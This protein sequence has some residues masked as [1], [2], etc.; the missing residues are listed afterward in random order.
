MFP[1]FFA[2]IAGYHHALGLTHD[3]MRGIGKTNGAA[4]V[5]HSVTTSGVGRFSDGSAFLHGIPGGIAVPILWKYMQKYAII[6]P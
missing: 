1:Y 2:G 5:T 3:K 4:F 6:A